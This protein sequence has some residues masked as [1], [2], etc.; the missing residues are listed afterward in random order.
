MTVATANRRNDYTSDGVQLV[1]PYGFLIFDQTH[2]IVTKRDTLGAETTLSLGIDYTVS[3]VGV[4]TGGNVTLNAAVTTGWALAIV[5]FM[6]EI[7]GT[8]LRNQGTLYP[9]TLETMADTMTMIALQL[10]D[11]ADRALHI[12]ISEPGTAAKVTVPSLR[13]SRILGFDSVGNL[14]MNRWNGSAVVG[15]TGPQGPV[16]PPGPAGSGGNTYVHTQSTAATTWNVTH[17][18]GRYASVVIKDSGGTRIWAQVDDVNTNQ[19]TITFSA[20]TSGTASFV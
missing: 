9:A 3:G 10:Q 5:R 17:N 8:S 14:S 19:A 1:F 15:D 6:P 16:G 12:P 13:A 4:P 20:A 2:L 11:Q 18:L 7:Q